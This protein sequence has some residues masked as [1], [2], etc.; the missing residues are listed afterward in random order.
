MFKENKITIILA[1]LA[2]IFS[3]LSYVNT[4]PKQE[5]ENGKS[6]YEIA[7][8]N[9]F[10]GS[11]TEWLESLQGNNGLSAYELAVQ[12]GFIGNEQEWLLSLIGRDGDNGK[13]AYEVAL[14]NGYTGSESDFAYTLFGSDDKELTKI[15]ISMPS[16]VVYGMV[17]QYQDT[18]QSIK[19]NNANWMGWKYWCP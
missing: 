18:I 7:L 4:L 19:I 2:L 14:E 6:A 11:E 15:A 8:E 1:T 9:G 10:K 3:C 5:V 12:N 16:N 17:N 13:S